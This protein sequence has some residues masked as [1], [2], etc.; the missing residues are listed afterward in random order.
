M[1]FEPQGSQAGRTD[2]IYYTLKHDSRPDM[3]EIELNVLKGQCLD[4]RIPDM[5]T[6]GNHGAA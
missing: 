6:I 4:R 5:E 3:A 2:E 1:P